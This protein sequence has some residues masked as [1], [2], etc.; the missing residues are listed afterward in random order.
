M[1]ASKVAFDHVKQNVLAQ[2]DFS[3]LKQTLMKIGFKD[4]HAFHML[5][6]CII[7]CLTYDKPG[8]EMDVPLPMFDKILIDSFLG[9]MSLSTDTTA[10][11]ELVTTGRVLRKRM[12][13]HSGLLLSTGIGDAAFSLRQMSRSNHFL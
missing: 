5:D 8:G 1:N 4:I 7:D 6:D 13:M 2:G 11:F 9:Y 10:T 3:P 12:L